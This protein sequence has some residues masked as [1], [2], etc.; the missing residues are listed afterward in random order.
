MV[1][2]FSLHKAIDPMFVVQI[3]KL[4]LKWLFRWYPSSRQDHAYLTLGRSAFPSR[5]LKRQNLEAPDKEA[6]A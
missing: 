4:Q 1:V 2:S 5:H 6:C 3:H